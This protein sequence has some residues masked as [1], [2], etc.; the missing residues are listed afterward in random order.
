MDI[1]GLLTQVKDPATIALITY[2]VITLRHI[3]DDLAEF[4]RNQGLEHAGLRA[5]IKTLYINAKKDR[6][7]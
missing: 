1:I 5:D 7:Q 3:N 2:L 6:E 4:K